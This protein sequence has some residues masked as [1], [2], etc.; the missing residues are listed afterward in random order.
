MRRLPWGLLQDSGGA[1][2]PRKILSENGIWLRWGVAIALF[3]ALVYG[4]GWKHAVDEAVGRSVPVEKKVTR[5][6]KNLLLVM[7]HLGIEPV[8]EDE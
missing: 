2:T 4:T 1:V 6:D 3:W 8:K 7:R 5:M